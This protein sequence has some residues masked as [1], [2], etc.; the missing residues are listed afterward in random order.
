MIYAFCINTLKLRIDEFWGLTPREA[1]ILLDNYVKNEEQSERKELANIMITA[2][3]VANFSNAKKLP[4]LKKII[5]EIMLGKKEAKK[6][7]KMSS[8]E[9]EQ[10]YHKKVVK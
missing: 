10:H 5:K 6:K 9:R 7:N 1:N 2:W 8:E 3:N 4:D